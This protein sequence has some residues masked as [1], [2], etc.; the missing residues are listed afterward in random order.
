MPVKKKSP[1][2]QPPEDSW[3]RA[4]RVMWHELTLA[5]MIGGSIMAMVMARRY[6][7]FLAGSLSADILSGAIPINE[8]VQRYDQRKEE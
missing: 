5:A 4:W 2:Y 1:S 8:L 7:N 6:I 3:Q